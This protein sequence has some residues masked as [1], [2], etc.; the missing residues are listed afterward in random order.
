MPLWLTVVIAVVAVV[1]LIGVA[2]Y[3]MN[4]HNVA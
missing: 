2:T 4:K 3:L 1:A